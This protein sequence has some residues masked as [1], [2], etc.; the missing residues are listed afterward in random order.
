MTELVNVFD[1]DRVQSSNAIYDYKRALWFNSEYIKRLDDDQFVTKIK[2]FLYLYGG[3]EWKEII[4]NSKDA[5]R[6]SFAPHIKTRLQTLRQ[7]AEFGQYFFLRP[8]RIDESLVYKTNMKA[9]AEVVGEYYN[10]ML[11]LLEHIDDVQ[12]QEE[13]LKDELLSFIKSRDLKNGQVLWPI[14][15]ILT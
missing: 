9:S 10:D 1:I 5:Y 4:E 12:R 8:P 7:F 2:D 14:R 11:D 15:A 13:I 3:E 6:L